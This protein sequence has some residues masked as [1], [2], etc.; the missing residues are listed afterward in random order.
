MLEVELPLAPERALALVEEAVEGWG[1]DWQSSPP[2]GR[3]ELPVSAGLRYGFVNGTADV[4]SAGSEHSRVQLW[5]ERSDYRIQFRATV[6]LAL[7]ALGG[8]LLVVMPFVPVLL[9]FLPLAGLLLLLA[10]FLVASQL[11]HRSVDDFLGWLEE[12]AQEQV[13]ETKR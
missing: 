2:G 11:R 3:F 8:L 1:G 9:D 10:W 4:S 12:L 7:G 6:V 13:E 5:I